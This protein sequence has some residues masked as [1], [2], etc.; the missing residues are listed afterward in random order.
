MSTGPTMLSAHETPPDSHPFRPVWRTASIESILLV[1]LTGAIVLLVQ[2]LHPTI[3]ETQRRLFGFTFA[4]LPFGLWLLISY[5]GERSVRAPRT[6]L[7]T[8]VILGALVANAIV[9]PL[10]ERVLN[11]D[12]W[13]TN[14]SGISRI[15]G[16][17]LAVGIPQEF[18]KYAVVRY[19]VWPGIYR[20]RIDGIAYA[21]A[22]AVGYATA[23]N[24]N[25]ALGVS[26]DPSAL[27]L[28]V[29]ETT[30]VQVAIGTI[31]GYM[32]ASFTLSESVSV[33]GLPAGL[34][35]SALLMGLAVT[36]RGGLVVGGVSPTSNAN[37]AVQGL[38]VAVALVL[39]LFVSLNF[40]INN[41]DERAALRNRSETLR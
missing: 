23:M 9:V 10:T 29:T 39:I 4:L 5:R 27:A 25:A 6:G 31:M 3:S 36:V 1:A 24:L 40:L 15:I 37:S 2:F 33:F 28:R 12:Q 30:L 34:L 13:L 11:V 22:A 35:L 32:L 20:E 21:M 38:G 41:A 7:L 18:L 14:A 8:V 17:T 19:S 16:Y 26:L